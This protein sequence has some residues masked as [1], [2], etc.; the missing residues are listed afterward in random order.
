MAAKSGPDAAT[1]VHVRDAA[2]LL[3]VIVASSAFY[4]L[5][6][7]RYSDDWWFYRH[8]LGSADQS[9][10]GLYDTLASVPWLA[11]RPGQIAW[12]ATFQTLFPGDIAATH[13]ANHAAFALGV[14][15][16]HAAL[17][18]MPAMR[19]AAYPVTLL[20]VAMP[21]FTASKFW[22]ANHMATLSFTFFAATALFAA[23]L[24]RGPRRRSFMALV[25]AIAVGSAASNLSYELFG[26]MLPLLPLAAW[27]ANGQPLR[28]ILHD[29]RFR[30]ATL[31]AAIGFGATTLFKT[32][33]GAAIHAPAT[34][35]EVGYFVARTGWMY[36]RAGYADFWTLGLYSPRA[37]VAI[38]MGPYF[39]FVAVIAAALA[40][41]SMAAR[42]VAVRKAPVDD[43]QASWRILVAAGV[44]AF[45]LGYLP[46]LTNFW[47]DPYPWGE[48]NR[49]NIGGALG[50][51]LAFCGLLRWV[52]GRSRVVAQSVLL[53]FC[54]IG[55][56]L[57]VATARIWVHAAARQDQVVAATLAAAGEL[58]DGDTVLIYGLCP[59]VGPAAVLRSPDDTGPRLMIASG[60][61]VTGDLIQPDTRLTPAAI[62]TNHYDR[63]K[64]RYPY[65]AV[66]IVDLPRRASARIEA[67]ADAQ[68]FFAAHPIRASSR[69][70]YVQGRGAPFY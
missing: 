25:A 53:V 35:G 64:G 65:R 8:M 56:F 63:L 46:F 19:S 44:I 16:L 40:L 26:F 47:V 24:A 67:F 2:V 32:A 12:Y 66:V 52:E 6:L 50:V 30:A 5:G 48:A 61:D 62:R 60:T 21:H 17:R 11:V 58:R 45:G 55:I 33:Y 41:A 7:G 36:L 1:L 38:A 37:A 3:A 27:L 57:Q 68:R 13:L 49:T 18:A 34:P 28:D 70:G 69:C 54:T 9:W 59:Y 31:A 22:Y 42:A 15:L 10:G 43:R 51:A 23:L 20:Y 14:L 4:V 29:G 39:E